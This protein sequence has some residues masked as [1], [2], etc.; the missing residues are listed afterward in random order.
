MH[1]PHSYL[2]SVSSHCALIPSLHP[3]SRIS[4]L[5]SLFFSSSISFFLYWIV[6][7]SMCCYFP[8]SPSS[9]C[10]MSLFPFTAKLFKRCWWLL[11][12]PLLFFSES[13]PFR[14]ST[15]PLHWRQPCQDYKSLPCCQMPKCW[16]FS[17]HLTWHDSSIWH[18]WS[19]P[20]GSSFS[21]W[22]LG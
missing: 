11:S 12:L 1:D 2:R 21:S 10:T 4:F 16:F 7:F 15:V 19:C 22:P 8:I 14:L 5:K 18:N 3:Y 6:L 20:S 9:C 13:T 17:P